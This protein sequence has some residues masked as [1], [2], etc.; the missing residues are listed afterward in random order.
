[1]RDKPFAE[2]AEQNKGPI[3]SVL[4]AWFTDPGS[5]LEVG[6]GTGQ[7]AVHFAAEMPHL[8]WQPTEVE[9]RLEGIEAWRL[10]ADLANLRAARLL[11]AGGIWPSERYDY[12]FT[13]NTAHIMHWPEVLATLAGVARALHR[14]GLFAMYGPFARG[15][16]HTAL[17][18]LEFDRSLR[19]MDPGMGVRDID[20]LLREALPLG[21]QLLDTVAM[22]ADNFTLIWCRGH[23]GEGTGAQRPQP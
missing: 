15:G 6:S 10:D 13:A 3:L 4:R 11:N 18:N 22:P 17:S 21:L 16:R 1:M 20:D 8:V 5:V 14:G 7:H 12:A 9:G 23:P 2:S 19:R